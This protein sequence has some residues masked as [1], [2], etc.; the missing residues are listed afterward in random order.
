MEWTSNGPRSNLESGLVPG[1][2]SVNG[3][4]GSYVALDDLP[5]EHPRIL[6]RIKHYLE[7]NPL[8]K[9]ASFNHYRPAR[10]FSD[11]IDSLADELSEQE[12]DRFQQAFT[13]LNK[14]L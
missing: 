5:K 7:N 3:E 13:A 14:L 6:C 1:G 11:N 9:D 12:L 2:R 10:Y 4:F 8:P